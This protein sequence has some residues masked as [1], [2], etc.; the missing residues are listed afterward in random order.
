M[1]AACLQQLAWV[2]DRP[3]ILGVVNNSFKARPTCLNRTMVL[4]LATCGVPL[5]VFSRCVHALLSDHP[6]APGCLLLA[7]T[8]PYL[9]LLG[10]IFFRVR[11]DCSFQGGREQGRCGLFRG[12]VGCGSISPSAWPQ[13]FARLVPHT[14]QTVSVTHLHDSIVLN[15]LL[16]CLTSS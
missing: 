12:L 2:P 7:N 8:L 1:V 3:A 9:V 4:L 11:C 13:R 6:S 5:H 10:G 15:I 16:T 14:T